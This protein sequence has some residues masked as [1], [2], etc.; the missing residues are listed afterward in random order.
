[1][2]TMIRLEVVPQAGIYSAGINE[3]VVALIME[4]REIMQQYFG[5]NLSGPRHPGPYNDSKLD[6][7]LAGSTYPHECFFGFTD[8]TQ[9]RTW[10]YSDQMLQEFDD[11]GVT[12]ACY[13]VTKRYDGN[14]QTCAP[15]E[16]KTP[17][18]V[19]W[20]ISLNE[21]LTKGVPI[22]NKVAS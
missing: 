8:E 12:L 14:T 7:S 5:G 2:Q 22:D 19:V 13:Q 11:R 6:R 3:T 15:L 21:F 10:F 4:C 16:D 20:R 1:M 18:N 9:L 17:E